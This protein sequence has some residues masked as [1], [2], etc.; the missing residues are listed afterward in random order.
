MRDLFAKARADQVFSGAAWSV[1]RSH[2]IVDR[3]VLGTLAW[4][5]EPVT[6]DTLWD[7]ASVTK[8]IF[9]LAV[10]R[11]IERGTLALSDPVEK[12]LP[13]YAGT[14]KA[15]L[16]VEQLL[17]HTSGMPGRVPLYRDH[18]TRQG[19]LDAVRELPLHS[20]PG[21]NVEYSSQGFMILGQLAEAAAGQPLDQLIAK[22]R[23]GELGFNPT[24]A[25]RCAATE[26]CR[27]R[28]RL[29]QGTVHD[30]NA[31]VLGGIAP[32]AGLF[33]TLD[34]LEDLAHS[35]LS[36]DGSF[37]KPGTLNEMTKPRTDHLE[38]RRTLAWQGAPTGDRLSKA[39]YGHTGFTGTSLWIDPEQDI[40]LVLLTNRVHP[41]REGPAGI[42]RVRRAFHAEALAG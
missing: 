14:D 11:L 18:P 31:D 36:N 30:E 34:A 8:P 19:L 23:M 40:F 41:R 2:G 13:D 21:T 26:Q 25:A 37:L 39:A 42:A 3:G 35:L 15:R 33:S 24:D 38:S 9:G 5:G 17:C 1:G 10:L 22:P 28:G 32:H 29:V 4:D 6:E 12:W 27:W 16:T 20:P 7:L